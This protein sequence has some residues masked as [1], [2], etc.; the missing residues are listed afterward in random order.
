MVTAN[1]QPGEV[2]SVHPAPDQLE[3]PIRRNQPLPE[4]LP[5]G[6]PEKPVSLFDEAIR[7]L[8]ECGARHD[9]AATMLSHGR[10][11]RGERAGGRTIVRPPPRG[12]TAGASPHRLGRMDHTT[13]FDRFAFS[14]ALVGAAGTP[15]AIIGGLRLFPVLAL[16]NAPG[17]W[18]VASGA[19]VA[20]L[21]TAMAALLLLVS[22]LQR[23]GPGPLVV[24]AGEALLAGLIGVIALAGADGVDRLGG[25]TIPAGLVIVAFLLLAGAVSER[26]HWR[27]RRGAALVLAAVLFVAVEV[28][29]GA[30]LL[31]DSVSLAP[32]G[33]LL[34]AAAATF[35][36][37]A[38]ILGT[39]PR[40]AVGFA[41]QAAGLAALAAARPGSVELV[42]GLGGLLAGSI[43]VVLGAPQGNRSAISFE[44]ELPARVDP[45]ETLERTA[46]EPIFDEAARLGRELRATIEELMLAR[47]TITLQRAELE[48]AATVDA[49]TGVASR[50]AIIERV[51]VEVAQA[52][53]YTHPFAIL[54]VDVD[55]FAGLNQEHGVEVGDEIL[56]EVALRI[57]LRVRR[58]DALGRSDGDSFLAILPHTDESGIIVFAEALRERLAQ[59]PIVTQAGAL[60]VTVSIGVAM[61][62]P[63]MELSA[64]D[65][66][67]RADEAL[68]SARKAGGNCIAFDRLHGLARIEPSR[69]TDADQ[70]PPEPDAERDSAASGD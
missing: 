69:G 26:I 51:R 52:R 4:G 37:A 40:L 59:R 18:L 53:R 31:S 64:D 27:L 38:I 20:A 17:L 34:L 19:A 9:R 67:G 33:L 41:L 48:R 42:V 50:G 68:N 66:L 2:I 24:A 70:A 25:G 8:Q 5:G 6:I 35:T 23:A 39:R 7:G 1:V 47:R 62:R 63:A 54:I 58:A 55:S 28:V 22:G 11:Y 56:R 29:L 43:A 15:L 16:D 44:R 46:D 13:T 60:S 45:D 65:L 21:T 12:Q 10:E 30:L 61:M 36:A 32:N 57:R 49:L 14:A 3:E